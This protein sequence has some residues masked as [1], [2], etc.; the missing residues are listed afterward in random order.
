M[1]ASW[2]TQGSPSLAGLTARE[3]DLL[4]RIRAAGPGIHPTRVA[5]ESLRALLRERLV[6]VVAKDDR[7]YYHLTQRGR[8]A[9]ERI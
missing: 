4:S 9:A 2:S 7:P 8:D 5:K 3:V 6:Y 1:A